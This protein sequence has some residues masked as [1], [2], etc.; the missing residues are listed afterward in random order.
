MTLEYLEALYAK[1]AD[2]ELV[3]VQRGNGLLLTFTGT[4]EKTLGRPLAQDEKGLYR[5]KTL[6]GA[7]TLNCISESG[8][9]KLGMRSNLRPV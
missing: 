7:Q 5:I 4:Q 8:L 3:K 2:K 6:R 1:F 9:Y